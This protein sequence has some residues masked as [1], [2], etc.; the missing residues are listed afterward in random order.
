MLV[1]IQ[2]QY[3]TR[4][5]LGAAHVASAN[6]INPATIGPQIDTVLGL[7]MVL[8]AQAFGAH[9]VK[10]LAATTLTAA[11]VA[12]ANAI[13]PATIEK[14][15]PPLVLDGA[16]AATGNAGSLMLTLTTAA[17]GLV[18]VAVGCNGGPVTGITG[19]G[20]TWTR[21]GRNVA[22]AVN[23]ELW[24]APSPAALAGVGITIN[25]TSSGFMTAV[26]FGINGSALA[27]DPN[28]ALPSVIGDGSGSPTTARCSITT[29]N[30][31]D[32]L[33]G[34]YR[35]NFTANPSEGVGWS[36]ISGANY[37]LVEYKIVSA[38]QAGLDVTISTG[39][40]GGSDDQN[41]G[42]ADAVMRA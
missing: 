23:I 29:S 30:A 37:M 27:F 15:K 14:A 12:S 33:I 21:R 11:H 4:R 17:A 28:G 31:E 22:S 25:Q 1:A 19:G 35:F 16:V 39:F 34:A 36:K 18:C 7:P 9:E 26:A 42:I 2:T 24:S 41:G 20:L 8:N 13:H 32:F 5:M 10:A 40:N 3:R 38:T 6:L